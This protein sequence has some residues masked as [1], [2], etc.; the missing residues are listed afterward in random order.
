LRDACTE[1]GKCDEVEECGPN[2]CET[3]RE[4]A[5]RN[6]SRDRV[7]GVVKAVDVIEDKGQEDE[8]DD[9]SQSCGHGRRLLSMLNNHTLNNV[10]HVLATVDRGFE[11]LVNLFPFQNS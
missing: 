8:D 11:L 9:E 1:D 2:Y 10:S 7:C 3:R 6:N 5:R 4:N